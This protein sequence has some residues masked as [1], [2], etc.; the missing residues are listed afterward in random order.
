MEQA[1]RLHPQLDSTPVSGGF[2]SSSAASSSSTGWTS[3]WSRVALPNIGHELGLQ[4]SSLQWVVSG[5][6]L[7]YGGLLLLGGR[8]ADLIGRRKVL[9]AGLAVFV[10]A[11]LIGGIANDGTTLIAT[12]FIKGASAAFTAPA[13]LSIITTTF[14]RGPGPEQGAQRLHGDRARA[15]GR[16]A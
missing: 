7:G 14:A 11:S 13:G 9:L 6:V 1:L 4:P 2:C 8:A 12:R 16:S 15:A 10:V 5:Y 3:P